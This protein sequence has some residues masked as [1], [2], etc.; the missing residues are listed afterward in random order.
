[1][2]PARTRRLLGSR[3]AVAGRITV[4]L[5]RRAPRTTRTCAT[6]GRVR[7]PSS[8]RL[9]GRASARS[10][11]STLAF[12]H[13]A[14]FSRQRRLPRS[15]SAALSESATMRSSFD[16]QNSSTCQNAVR[17]SIQRLRAS[18]H[19]SAS[20]RPACCRSTAARC[21]AWASHETQGFPARRPDGCALIRGAGDDARAVWGEGRRVNAGEMSFE[22]VQQRPARAVPHTRGAVITS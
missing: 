15:A 2:R 10:Q 4:P 20:P 6:G 17:A 1:M 3:L 19:T 11:S 13:A 8:T 5:A 7:A 14:T 12:R 16:G 9:Q 18:L 22:H 21:L